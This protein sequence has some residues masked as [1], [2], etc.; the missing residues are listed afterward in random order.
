MLKLLKNLKDSSFETKQFFLSCLVLFI[1]LI[2][3]LV[4]CYGRLNY[5]RSYAS[6]SQQEKRA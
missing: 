2:V 4:Y 1:L 3:T 5:D 6:T